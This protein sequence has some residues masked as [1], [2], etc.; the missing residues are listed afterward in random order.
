VIEGRTFSFPEVANYMTR[1]S[2]SNYI[3][4]VDLS[5]IEQKDALKT[6]SFIISCKVNP[7]V[8]MDN[9]SSQETTSKIKP[10]Q[11]GVE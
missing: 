7:E 5:G 11:G 2:E 10:H 6:F 8:E 1:L 3:K 9:A 4:T